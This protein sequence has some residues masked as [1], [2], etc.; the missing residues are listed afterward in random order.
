MKNTQFVFCQTNVCKARL[1]SST[2][3]HIKYDS[4]RESGAVTHNHNTE[5]CCCYCGGSIEATRDESEPL[6]VLYNVFR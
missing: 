5:M 2:S 3:W 6:S 1:V 4:A